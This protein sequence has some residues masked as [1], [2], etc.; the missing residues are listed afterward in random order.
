MK[1]E[2]ITITLGSPIEISEAIRTAIGIAKEHS[3]IVYMP[4]N[5]IPL[6]VCPNDTPSMVEA[7][8][9]A[10]YAKKVVT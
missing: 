3:C 5:G 2:T 1:I 8:Y 10:E 4:F 7:F 6:V 9:E